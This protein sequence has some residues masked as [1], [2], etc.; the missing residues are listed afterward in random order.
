MALSREPRAVVGS[1]VGL[2]SVALICALLGGVHDGLSLATP[3]LLLVVPVL[4]A[5]VLGGLW[6]SVLTGFAAAV[7]FN[8]VFIPP[9]F[10]LQIRHPEDVIAF[11]VFAG[12][13][14]V[15]GTLVN[16]ESSR[17][18]HA[19]RA[20]TEIAAMHTALVDLTAEREVLAVEAQ[21]VALLEAIDRQR[22]I[23]L[24]SV[25]HD[26]R[27][28]LM[29]ISAVTTDLRS[30]DVYVAATRNDLLDLVI[31]EAERLD[32]LVANLLSMSRIEAGVLQP[33]LD[34]VD[35]GEV[36]DTSVR[37]L[38]R[39]LGASHVELEVEPDLPLVW[40][41]QVLLDQVLTNLLE[42]AVRH[43]GDHITISAATEVV[44]DGPELVRISVADDGAGL[45]PALRD[46]V[47][48]PWSS[49]VEGSTTGL[50]L[51]ICRSIVECHGGNIEVHDDAGRGTRFTFALAAHDGEDET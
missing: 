28:P 15:A 9:V 6:P 23:L 47:F 36:I 27:T 38:R 32:R 44:G 24:R 43:G 11:V 13:A 50:G 29:T 4:L 14:G 10:T 26:L 30:G 18:L 39:L 16:R 22:S 45:D 49:S 20:A 19:E 17:R 37:R 46:R 40:A 42:N 25:S 5:A 41:D 35:T 8:I 12:V 51:A 48:E 1:G 34:L 3:A 33:H 7:A 31:A 2:A 21:K